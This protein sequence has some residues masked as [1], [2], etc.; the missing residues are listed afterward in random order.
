MPLS[1]E[2][3]NRCK[4]A[5]Q[6]LIEGNKRFAENKFLH[7]NRSLETREAVQQAQNPFAIILGCSDSRASPEIIFDQGIGDLFVVRVAGNVAG[8]IETDSIDYSALT[9]GS[10]LILVLGHENCGAVTAVVNKTTQGIEAIAQLIQPAIHSL[11]NVNEAVKAN[12]LSVVAQLKKSPI[13]SKLIKEG[14]IDVVGGYYH[15]QNGL[16]EF[17]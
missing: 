2:E 6:R 15:F 8:E 5:L 1:A 11:T 13:I 12:V 14:K 3:D 10:C 7:P 16:V 17:L 4:Q 9:L